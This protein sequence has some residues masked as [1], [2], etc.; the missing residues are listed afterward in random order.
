MEQARD[1]DLNTTPEMWEDIEKYPLLGL[2][3]SVKDNIIVKGTDCT[4]GLQTHVFRDGP[5]GAVKDGLVVEV[6]KKAG[7]IPFLKSNV[8]QY[9]MAPET[10]NN[11][12]GRTNNF[13]NAERVAGGSSGGEGALVASNSSVIG[14]GTDIMGN[15]RIPA[16]F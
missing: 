14:L 10:D 13:H 9:A 11:L 5:N 12:W 16:L 7:G 1:I 6:I 2:P 3:I 4:Y 8:P 15:I